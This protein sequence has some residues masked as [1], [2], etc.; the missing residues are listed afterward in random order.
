MA[1][2]DRTPQQVRDATAETERTMAPQ[3]VP[4]NMYETSGALV[5]LAPLPAVTPE[6]VN[7]ELRDGSL[8]FWA[9]LRS[10]GTREYLV[11]EWDYGGYERE[12][13]L[14]PGYGSGLEATLANG[15]LAVRVLRG[16]FTGD[17]TVKPQL[18]PR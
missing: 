13:E 3:Q 7:V 14:P 9:S 11:Q 5:V 18:H 6:D 16:D 10:A 8:R 4:V 12:L 15:Q 1:A 17:V 2:E